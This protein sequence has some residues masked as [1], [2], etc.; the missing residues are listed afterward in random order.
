MPEERVRKVIRVGN[1]QAITI[2]KPWLSYYERKNGKKVT[3]VIV[4]S[5]GNLIIQP[6][7]KD[8]EEVPK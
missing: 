5:N 4:T 1:S 8:S 2:P 7:L 6:I 3:D